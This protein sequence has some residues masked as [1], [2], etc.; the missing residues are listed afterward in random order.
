MIHY[1]IHLVA[2]YYDG[3]YQEEVVDMMQVTSI[4]M[5]CFTRV[6]IP[7]VEYDWLVEYV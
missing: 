4:C 1:C 7:E 5:A 2:H 6:S 3:I